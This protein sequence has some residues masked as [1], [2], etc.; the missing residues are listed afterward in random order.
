MGLLQGVRPVRDTGSD[1]KEAPPP[2]RA[3]VPAAGKPRGYPDAGNLS[4]QPQT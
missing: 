2:P 1:N 3:A 4:P